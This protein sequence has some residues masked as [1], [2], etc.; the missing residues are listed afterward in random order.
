MGTY[1]KVQKYADHKKRIESGE[2]GIVRYTIPMRMELTRVLGQG[3]QGVACLFE[4]TERDGS[5]R[6]MVIKAAKRS[7]DLQREF[8]MTKVR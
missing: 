2:F 4:R 5:R 8:T 1:D 3:G 7:G 6:K